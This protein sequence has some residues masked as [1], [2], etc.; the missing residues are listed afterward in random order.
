MPLIENT[1]RHAPH[2]IYLLYFSDR[3]AVKVG[4]AAKEDRPFIQL[5]RHRGVLVHCTDYIFE[6]EADARAVERRIL[7]LWGSYGAERVDKDGR[8]T[9][10]DGRSEWRRPG[11]LYDA[12]A[13]LA[14]A[15]DVLAA[16]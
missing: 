7:L 10:D 14:V 6:N 12:E 16:C 5:R 8:R 4:I 13:L 11:D 15:L 1:R 2:F 9:L 3:D